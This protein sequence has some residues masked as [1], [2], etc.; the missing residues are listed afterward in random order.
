[1]LGSARSASKERNEVFDRDAG[2]ADERA[3]RALGHFSMVGNREPAIRRSGVA[4]DDVAAPLPIDLVPELTEG[5]DNL[6]PRDAG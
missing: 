6:A 4:E 5:G 3:Q 2:L 1:M